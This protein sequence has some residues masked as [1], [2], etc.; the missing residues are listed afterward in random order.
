[1]AKHKVRITQVSRVERSITVEVEAE[2][3]EE[4]VEKQDGDAAPPLSDPRWTVESDDLQNETV[5]PA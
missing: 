3:M 2:T 4:A 1:M 5:E